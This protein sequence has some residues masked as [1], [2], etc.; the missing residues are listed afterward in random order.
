MIPEVYH[1]SSDLARDIKEMSSLI[2]QFNKTKA[3]F[4]KI[5]KADHLDAAR[6]EELY[7]K[8]QASLA[9]SISGIMS[10]GA[11]LGQGDL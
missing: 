11:A 7:A 1:S 5:D 6:K 3:L 10:R 4:K 2:K 9:S 8:V